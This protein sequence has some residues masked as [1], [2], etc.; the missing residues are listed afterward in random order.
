MYALKYILW[1]ACLAG[2]LTAS[3]GCSSLSLIE[4]VPPSPPT[5]AARF[6]GL[7][8]GAPPQ[9]QK[10]GI[11]FEHPPS[12]RALATGKE[13]P[14]NPGEVPGA[15]A[16]SGKHWWYGQ[17]VGRTLTNVGLVFLFPPYALYLLGNGGLA[18]AGFEEVHVTDALPVTPREEALAVYDGFTSLPGR[19]NALV[20]GEA[21]MQDK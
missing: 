3:T 1:P 8:P 21:Y 16:K 13:T 15:L 5:P 10:S 18:L 20:A 12:I 17:G 14:P 19:F 11:S 7:E 4:Q 6:S 2:L 9:S